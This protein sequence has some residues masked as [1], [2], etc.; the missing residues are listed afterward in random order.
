MIGSVPRPILSTA[1]SVSRSTPTSVRGCRAAVLELHL[2]LRG[3]RDHVVVGDD[4]AVHVVDDPGAEAALD[5]L[6]VVRP[7]VAEQL[8]ELRRQPGDIRD[9]DAPLRINVDDRG[10]GRVHRVR[11]THE[12]RG[13]RRRRRASGDGVGVP[14]ASA[15]ASGVRG[16]ASGAGRSST[17]ASAAASPSATQGEIQRNQPGMPDISAA[18]SDRPCIAVYNAA[19]PPTNENRPMSE[20][21]DKGRR[22]L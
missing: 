22:Q 5:A 14:S 12:L 9:D 18:P 2:D 10:R 3:A 8:R 6:A 13:R 16:V 17:Q 11:V 21:I 15:T 4:V 1:R 7:D 20:A 19:I